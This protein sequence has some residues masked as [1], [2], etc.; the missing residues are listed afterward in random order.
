MG[1]SFHAAP[2]RA[3]AAR[4]GQG[5][6]GVLGQLPWRARR[7]RHWPCSTSCISCRSRRRRDHSVRFWPSR[8][9]LHQRTD[10]CTK[11]CWPTPSSMSSCSSSTAIL[12]PSPG[13]HGAALRWR[14]AFGIVWPQAAR[15]AGWARPGI[16]RAFQLLLRGGWLPQAHDP[17]VAALSGPPRLPRHRGDVDLG[18]AARHDAGPPG[19]SVG[20]AG[21][22]RRTLA[23]WRPGGAQPS[24]TSPF[25]RSP[26]PAWCRR[27]INT[28]LPASLLDRFAGDVAERLIALLRFLTP[29]RRRRCRPMRASPTRRGCASPHCGERLVPSLRISEGGR[30]GARTDRGCM[31]VGRGC[32]SR[33]S[34][35]CWRRR[36]RRAR[37]A[38]HC[39]NWRRANGATRAPARRS[40]SASPPSSGGSIAPE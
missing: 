31:S 21:V 11:P 8:Q 10:P 40:A 30:G 27:S 39:S 37:C 5:G 34:V 7:P 18:D 29:D 9:H 4:T 6:A 24:P 25:A 33:L 23:R 3:P 26:G 1:R 14:A 16:C 20:R 35:R 32:A 13:R 36:R 15:L 22:D 2:V 12:R 19:A 28:G 38:R 17:A